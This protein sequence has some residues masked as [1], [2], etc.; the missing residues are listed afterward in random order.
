MKRQMSGLASASVRE[1]MLNKVLSQE[2]PTSRHCK[3]E[4]RLR[5]VS[6][7]YKLI[8]DFG[9]RLLHNR[10][11]QD[12]DYND[13]HLENLLADFDYGHPPGVHSL[14]SKCVNTCCTGA[15]VQEVMASLLV[16]CDVRQ[17]VFSGDRMNPRRLVTPYAGLIDF[18]APLVLRFVRYAHH[19]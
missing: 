19:G 15:H 7:P 2:Y 8:A 4:P 3:R 5:K 1:K 11:P 18:D 13:D 10:L 17:L 14:F 6:A 12:G 16:N 9:G